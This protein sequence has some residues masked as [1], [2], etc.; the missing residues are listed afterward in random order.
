MYRIVYRDMHRTL[1]QQEVNEI[2][3]QI[4]EAAKLRL[5]V[6]IGKVIKH[7]YYLKFVYLYIQTAITS[8]QIQHIGKS[9]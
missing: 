7:S 6:Q 1:T 4:E 8:H 2:H 9:Q 3:S 5:G